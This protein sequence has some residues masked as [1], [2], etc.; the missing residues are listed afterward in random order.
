M[1][2][3]II[4]TARVILVVGAR[5]QFVKSVPVIR[6]ICSKHKKAIKLA[7]DQIIV[8]NNRCSIHSPRDIAGVINI[9]TGSSELGWQ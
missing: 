3:D 5:P 6:E 8:E 1:E 9:A 4:T 2:E 7:I